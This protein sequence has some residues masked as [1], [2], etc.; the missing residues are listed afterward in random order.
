[1]GLVPPQLGRSWAEP[2]CQ[3]IPR[4]RGQLG[5]TQSRP[6]A[7]SSCAVLSQEQE[8][9]KVVLKTTAFFVLFCCCWVVEVAPFRTSGPLLEPVLWAE[10]SLWP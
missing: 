3:G 9:I 5:V 4:E 2:L 6:Q 8:S 10:Q 7:V 1:M